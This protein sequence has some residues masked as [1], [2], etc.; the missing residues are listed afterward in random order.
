MLYPL[1]RKPTPHQTRCPL[2]N[3]DLIMRRNVVA[4]RM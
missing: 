1:A 4:V 2:G 3:N